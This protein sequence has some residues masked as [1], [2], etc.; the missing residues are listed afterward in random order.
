MQM[1]YKHYISGMH[2]VQVDLRKRS[3]SVLRKIYEMLEH[4]PGVGR[5]EFVKGD[6][7]RSQLVQDIEILFE[8]H[9]E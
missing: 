7:V 3:D 8:K 6:I 9:F 5:I 1:I 2:Y 4:L